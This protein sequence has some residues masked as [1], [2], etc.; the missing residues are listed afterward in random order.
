MGNP[1]LSDQP[2]SE[3]GDSQSEGDAPRRGRGL[4]PDQT[5]EPDG[6]GQRAREDA[7]PEGGQAEHDP[8]EREE[9]HA[10]QPA[11]HQQASAPVC[12]DYCR[13]D[14]DEPRH[15]E[16]V[17]PH[18]AGKGD[19]TDKR[20]PASLPPV[21]GDQRDQQQ[22]KSDE[23]RGA[24]HHEHRIGHHSGQVAAVSYE[25]LSTVLTAN[26]PP[27]IT[28]IG[29]ACRLSGDSSMN[30]LLLDG[31]ARSARPV[32]QWRRRRESQTSSA[33]GEVSSPH[34]DSPWV[35]QAPARLSVEWPPI[36][37][38]ARGIASTASRSKPKS[39]T[40][41]NSPW[42]CPW[43]NGSVRGRVWPYPG[44]IETPGNV[45]RNRSPRRP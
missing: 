18:V 8:T 24:D 37:S 11:G 32:N 38:R 29:P 12:A 34:G 1:V 3:C 35:I 26:S 2:E 20:R 22:R 36:S 13:S 31:S 15:G 16:R 41:F 17:E 45:T 9:H 7:G 30:I 14:L 21:Q 40:R 44:S 25:E 10:D 42:S 33:L 43:S 4:E 28:A 5:A 23:V 6:D 39:R 19:R 27:A